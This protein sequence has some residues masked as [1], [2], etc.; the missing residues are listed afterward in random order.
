MGTYNN[1]QWIADELI[2]RKGT[3][4]TA[5]SCTGGMIGGAFTDLAGSSQWFTGGIIAYSN[6]VK[7]NFL[8]V[9]HDI[10][11]EH[12]A[13]SEETVLAMAKNVASKFTADCSIAVSGIAG[14]GGGSDKKPLGLVWIGIHCY[15]K[16]IACKNIFTGGRYGVRI[17]TVEKSVELLMKNLKNI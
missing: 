13:V 11:E 5:E 15:G 2:R 6:E 9:P 10:L 14:P 16:T 7:E 12:G 3:L 17:Q 1:I 8:S 4:V